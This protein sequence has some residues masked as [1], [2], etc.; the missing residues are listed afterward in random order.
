LGWH[1]NDGGV[2][3]DGVKSS[4]KAAVFEAPVEGKRH[5]AAADSSRCRVSGKWTLSAA[6]GRRLTAAQR[7]RW[8]KVKAGKKSVNLRWENCRWEA[9]GRAS[10][11]TT[12]GE[13]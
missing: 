11:R 9:A 3:A 2:D 4:G 13:V 8:A 10:R 7:A 5:P 12:R 6:G 1:R